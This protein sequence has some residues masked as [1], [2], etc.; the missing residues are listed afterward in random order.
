MALRQVGDELLDPRAE[1]VGE[2]RGRR[3]DEGVD[4][5]PCRLVAHGGEAYR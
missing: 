5:V 3:P 4:V 2:V 1:L